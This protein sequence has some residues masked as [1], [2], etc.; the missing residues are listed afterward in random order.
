MAA[1]K[2]FMMA[3]DSPRPMAR[4]KKA[5]LIPSRPG[6]PKD[7]LDT[8]R[9]VRH[10]KWVRISSRD[11]RVT[12][13]ASGAALTAM[14]RGSKIM[15]SRPIPYSAAR[16]KIRSAMAKRPWAVSG[17]PLSSKVRATTTPPYFRARGNTASMLSALPLTELIMALPL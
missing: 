14:A 5:A 4:A 9:E 15:S 6:R 10:P 7:T 16:S 2:G 3:A 11:S 13:A 12:R 1:E 8:P 17:I